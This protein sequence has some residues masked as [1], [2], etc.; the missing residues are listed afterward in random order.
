M[1]ST[2]SYKNVIVIVIDALR[3]KNLSCYGYEKVT[4][5]CLDRIAE[6]GALFENA[7]A[8]SD[9]TDVS[10]TTM[11][12]GK[13]PLSH[14]IIH[15]GTE[16]STKEILDLNRTSTKFL[17]EILNKEGYVTIALDWLGR[18]HKRG[19]DLYGVDELWDYNDKIKL[20][21]KLPILRQGIDKILRQFPFQQY[22]IFSKYLTQAGLYAGTENVIGYFDLGLSVIKKI[23]N[24]FFMLIHLWDVHTPLT[25]TPK[26]F[27]NKFNHGVK[28][29][30]IADMVMH[31]KNKNWR[32]RT[33]IHLKGLR[34]IS[35]IIPTYDGSINFVDNYL[36]KFIKAL[37]NLN[38][39]D[40]T[41]LIIIADHGDNLMRDGLFIGHG[42]L[43]QDVLKIPLIINGPGIPK[44]K[45][46]SGFVQHI[47]LVPT[48]LELLGIESD[49]YNFDGK[50]L[51]SMIMQPKESVRSY[52]FA[53][54]SLAKKRYAFVTERFKYIYSPTE[55]DG[56]DEYDTWFKNTKELYDLK[57]D[58]Y[59]KENLIYKRPDVALNMENSLLKL[60][61][62]LERSKKRNTLSNRIREIKKVL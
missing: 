31:I 11:F 25:G 21:S 37:K 58:S 29:N 23:R 22:T 1:M 45:K 12:S 17:S 42:G 5:P 24:P 56:K 6:E 2:C 9:H 40:N 41:Y 34:Y 18:W 27:V 28:E 32:R 52:A 43:Y 62:R 35:E 7:Y 57:N 55:K 38:V 16:V 46:I 3:S 4:S 47:D 51:V 26:A 8:C 53:V 10:F 36:F 59:E 48:I 60:I 61:N 49:K 30:K 54:S 13:Y 20:F 50:S 44:K 14:G 15:H 33:R 39:L 19:F